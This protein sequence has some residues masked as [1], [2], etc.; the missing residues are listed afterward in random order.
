MSI[1]VS[2]VLKP[3]RL[4]LVLVV[5]MCTTVFAIGWALVF[6]LFSHMSR[7]WAAI[8]GSSCIG[9]SII[10]IYYNLRSRKTLG[11]DI[12]GIGQIRLNEY[13]VLDKVAAGEQFLDGLSSHGQLVR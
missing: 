13:T 3:S 1:A 9:A 4:L 5:G 7:F 10:S 12:S 2:T 8:I 11:I 6:G